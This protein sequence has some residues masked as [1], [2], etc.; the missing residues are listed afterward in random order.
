MNKQALILAL[1]SSFTSFSQIPNGAWIQ[2]MA[3]NVNENFHYNPNNPNSKNFTKY[4]FA[5]DNLAIDFRPFDIS[6]STEFNFENN[7]IKFLMQNLRITELSDSV[8]ILEE[9]FQ[10]DDV[11]NQPLRKYL[12]KQS[13]LNHKLFNPD[14]E[15]IINNDTIAVYKNFGLYS[16]PGLNREEN[17]LPIP[18]FENLEKAFANYIQEFLQTGL[19]LK[20]GNY[21]KISF[22]V[23]ENGT[24]SNQEILEG[25][26]LKLNKALLKSLE[27]SENKWIAPIVDG[28]PIRT[29]MII[30]IKVIE[31]SQDVFKGSRL[32]EQ[33]NKMYTK[34]EFESCIDLYTE[35]F[36]LNPNNPDAI[37]NRASAYYQIGDVESA[38]KDW[39]YIYDKGLNY[40]YLYLVE[41][42]EFN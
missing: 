28:K 34:N 31:Q 42:C 21:A 7:T 26:N 17:Y 33:A 12:V 29:K 20:T 24:V 39:K 8:M 32:L 23:E 2:V 4:V 6:K 37:F 41:Y 11:S 27:G 40:S 35:S 36:L 22:Y 3:E 14:K 38:C 10:S 19:N 18:V 13:Y 9:T 5:D 15:N 25:E 16:G 1:F 30:P